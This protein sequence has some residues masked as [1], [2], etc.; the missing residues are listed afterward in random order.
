ML[1]REI[2]ECE[3]MIGEKKK[4]KSEKKNTKTKIE[5]MAGD[6]RI[7]AFQMAAGGGKEKNMKGFQ[8][9]RNTRS[10]M[11]MKELFSNR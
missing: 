9:C 6:I 10:N 3:F 2:C 11:G 7:S 8:R 5:Q 4:Q 1:P